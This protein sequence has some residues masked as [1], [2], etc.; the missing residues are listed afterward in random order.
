MKIAVIG[1]GAM[2]GATVE[3]LVKGHLFKTDDITISDPSQEV[4][5]K[6]MAMGVSVTTDNRLAAEMAD[7]V[8]VVVKP[9]LVQLVLDDI[10]EALVPS[11]QLLIVIAAGVSSAN[12][13]QWLGNSCPPLFLVI[14]NIAIAEQQS[15]TFVVPVT[16]N[17]EQTATVKRI[18]DEM[19]ST[20]ITDEQHLAAGTTLASCG[21]AY[22]MRYI[23]AA[24][25]GGVELGFKADDAKQ[26]VMQTVE[27]AVRLL[28]TTGMHPE[29]AIDLV[30]TPGG[31]TIKGLNEMEHAGFTSAVIRGLKAGLK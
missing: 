9:W 31:V 13:R 26:I 21:I 11:R 29:Q 23:R 4:L 2:G 12:I 17:E 19:G 6:F 10:R 8:C 14:P 22:A 15:M 28:A 7:V 30:T 24:A 27:G 25:E 3:G 20:L 18:F 16:A 5:D 1:A